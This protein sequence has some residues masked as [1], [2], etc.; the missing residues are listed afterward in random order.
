MLKSACKL[1]ASCLF[2]FINIAVRTSHDDGGG[3]DNR[4]NSMIV[5]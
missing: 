5:L 1:P 4:D 2:R 3:M